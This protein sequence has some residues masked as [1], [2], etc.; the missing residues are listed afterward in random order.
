MSSKI[1]FTEGT[2]LKKQYK[3]PKGRIGTED[4]LGRKK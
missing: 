1:C 3:T 2:G 4:K